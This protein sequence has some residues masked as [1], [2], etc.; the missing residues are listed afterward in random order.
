MKL[1]QRLLHL[2]PANGHAMP[3]TMHLSAP[4]SRPTP[5]WLVSGDS[6]LLELPAIESLRILNPAKALAMMKSSASQ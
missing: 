5:P 1:R 2:K 4:H 6:D 3:M